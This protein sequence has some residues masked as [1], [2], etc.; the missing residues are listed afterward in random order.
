MPV[1]G[2]IC[3]EVAKPQNHDSHYRS[4][5]VQPIDEMELIVCQG[6]PRKYWP[7]AKRNLCLAMAKKY[8][9]R[10][11]TKEGESA[12]KDKEKQANYLHRAE[13]GEWRA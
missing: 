10:A 11:G 6:I 3:G 13:H 2:R 9:L 12:E 4:V 7:V 1:K 5:E 8:E